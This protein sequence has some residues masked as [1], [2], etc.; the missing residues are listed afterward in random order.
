MT[1]T[2][3]GRDVWFLR[4]GKH[5][6]GQPETKEEWRTVEPM[7]PGRKRVRPEDVTIEVIEFDSLYKAMD[8]A[9]DVMAAG[10]LG[11]IVGETTPGQYA[12]KV[13]K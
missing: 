10:Y 2:L 4:D 8:Y 7:I 1:V 13:C 11:A 9:N 12:V 5:V 6:F 3:Q